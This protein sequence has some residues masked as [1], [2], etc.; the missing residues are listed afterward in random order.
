MMYTMLKAELYALEAAQHCIVRVGNCPAL[1][2]TNRCP[3]APHA[4]R[5]R[6][7]STDK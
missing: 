6:I 3:T 2:S 4:A 5:H 7:Y 1:H